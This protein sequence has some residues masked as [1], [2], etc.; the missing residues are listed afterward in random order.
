ML[1]EKSGLPSGR[2]ERVPYVPRLDMNEGPKLGSGNYP[3]NVH[4]WV[5]ELADLKNS[6]AFWLMQQR[7][8]CTVS[9]LYGKKFGQADCPHSR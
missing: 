5:K 6:V 8:G 4:N 7:P 2:G 3:L 9:T 1:F